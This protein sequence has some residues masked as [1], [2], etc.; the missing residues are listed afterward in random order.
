MTQ[1]LGEFYDSPCDLSSPPK[2]DDSD[3]LQP[4][5]E[6][7]NELIDKIKRVI[8][9]PCETP[10]P[11][12]FSFKFTEEGKAHNLNILRKYDFDL[13]KALN[14][15]QSSS[16]G[17]VKEFKP[18]AVLEDIFGLHPL[19][20]RMKSIL[21]NGSKWPVTNISND[22]RQKD[23]QDALAFGNHK[24]ATAKPEILKKLIAKDVKY[25]Y[26]LPIPLDHVT[27]IPGLVMA[28]MNIMAQNTIDEFGRIVP[29][30]RLTHDQSWKWSSGTSVNS[31]VQN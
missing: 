31:C 22:E 13:G 30:D 15:Q 19:W 29:K 20:P 14:A 25:G 17:Y 16:L 27:S 3:T 10:S 7:P 9:T 28:A 4:S 1:L 8:A 26:S 24:G 23:I 5:P 2:R 12:E 21:E 6:W 18:S 11:P